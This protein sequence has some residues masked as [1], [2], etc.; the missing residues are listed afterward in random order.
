MSDTFI[1][2]YFQN[3]LN[4]LFFIVLL[5]DKTIL[6]YINQTLKKEFIN[7]AVLLRIWEF[8]FIQLTF[9]TL[10]ILDFA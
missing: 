8:L 2:M 6:K 3:L 10:Y 5:L 7:K 9:Y 1:R 4:T